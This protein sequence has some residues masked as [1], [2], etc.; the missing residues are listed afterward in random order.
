M[1]CS[2]LQAAPTK[3]FTNRAVALHT[4]TSS[5]PLACVCVNIKGCSRTRLPPRRLALTLDCYNHFFCCNRWIHSLHRRTPSTVRRRARRLERQHELTFS[6]LF[7]QNKE[8]RSLKQETELIPAGVS[9]V[10]QNNRWR[11]PLEDTVGR[12]AWERGRPRPWK[13]WVKVAE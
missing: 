9:V 13:W 1:S 8:T 11:I 6:P 2:H 10:F 12:V 7:Q 3:V 5:A 4:N